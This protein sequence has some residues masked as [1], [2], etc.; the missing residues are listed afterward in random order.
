MFNSA[1]AVL[2]DMA[3][4]RVPPT[5]HWHYH[6][7][8]GEVVGL[9]V[10]FDPPGEKKY[11]SQA[12]RTPDGTWTLTAMPAARPLYRLPAVVASDDIVVVT[13]GEKSADSLV[14]I[15]MVATTSPGGCGAPTFADWS[16]LAGR[17]VL[18]LPDHDGPGESYAA[19][20]VRLVTEA[21]AARVAV[22]RL[23]EHWSGMPA[24]GDAHDWVEAHDA[25]DPEALREK[26]V[27]LATEASTETDSLPTK[28]DT[29]SG[30]S[31]AP[32]A[33]TPMP[34]APTLQWQSLPTDL[35]PEPLR[36]FVTE[37]ADGIGIDDAM[38]T[39]PL[40]A[41][42]A[43]AVGNTRRVELKPGWVE[44]PVLWCAT[45]GESGDGKSPGFR[46]ALQFIEAEQRER[47]RDHANALVMWEAEVADHEAAVAEWKRGR[48]KEG[49]PDHPGG[50]PTRPVPTRYLVND[51]TL[52]AL[53]SV[54]AANPR[55]L[56]LAVD[57]LAGWLASFDQYR[58]G[59]G[60]SDC[61]KWLSMY[62][63]GAV[64]VDR[65]LSGTLHVPSAAVSVC[66][67]IQPGP[68]GRALGTQHVEN[69]LLARLQLAM[70]PSR[71]PQWNTT[72]PGF[73]TVEDMTRLFG[74]LLA[75]PA[76]AAPAR[77]DLDPDATDVFKAYWLGLAEEREATTGPVRSM[78]AKNAAVAGRL[79]LVL[80]TVQQAHVGGLAV[81]GRIDA[82]TMNRAV[83]IARWAA[84]ENRRVY[85]LVLA[86]DSA[87]TT[88]ADDDTA[89]AWV[90]SRGGFCS[91]RDIGRGLV[92][93]KA[94]GAAEAVSRRLVA[95]G[96]AVWAAPTSGGRPADGI[97][98]VT[99]G[100]SKTDG[101]Q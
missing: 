97:R 15:G 6:D 46:A 87:T 85:S 34:A 81:P 18:V 10:R 51:A 47:F 20:V 40:L 39:F 9:V 86:D 27:K 42:L 32:A 13:E 28:V 41:A 76:G 54:L 60:G 4:W 31:A 73:A 52:E 69:G 30:E 36:T 78:L 43:S 8:A 53:V 67:G 62:D 3:R 22:V 17:S 83:G 58:S 91:V 98:L 84:A 33:T 5:M 100:G 45:V 55:G 64:V 96:R 1:E 49:A 57:E 68:L 24:G 21:G 71:P 26:L 80:H 95:A 61:P 7:A 16:T 2:A 89:V 65:K 72:T 99:A 35:L 48:G 101:W 63:A 38:V 82:D 11:F 59:R 88:A 44:A 79:A 74:S 90:A 19:D 77:V 12:S 14:G 94:P 93:F 66:G 37:A 75:V 25:I 50:K 29:V 23:A 56:L 92:R 70:P